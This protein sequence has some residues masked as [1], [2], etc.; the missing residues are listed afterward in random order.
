MTI[1]DLL[2]MIQFPEKGRVDKKIFKKAIYENSD[3]ST[4]QVELIKKDVEDI[5]WHYV[6]KPETINIPIFKDDD[7]EYEEI[8]VM[9]VLIREENKVSEIAGV[10][11]KVVAYPVILLLEHNDKVSISVALKRTNKA[12]VSKS[13]MDEVHITGFIDDPQKN[14]NANTFIQAL[15]INNLSFVNLYEFYGDFM[16]RVKLFCVSEYLNIFEYSNKQKTNKLFL[17]YL[18]IKEL[19]VQK[20]RL[21]RQIKSEKEFS[22]RVTLNV[23]SKKISEKLE[24]IIHKLNR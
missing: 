9:G 14:K 18:K 19:E 6:L 20:I 11:Q 23:S 21:M 24:D 2:D 12:D 1:Q 16:D 15:G 22:K 8:Q 13:V 5:R 10:I 7:V 3:L 17:E 4:K